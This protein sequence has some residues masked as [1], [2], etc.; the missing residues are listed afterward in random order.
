MSP[1]RCSAFQTGHTV[2]DS[3]TVPRLALGDALQRLMAES[4]AQEEPEE[5]PAVEAPDLPETPRAEGYKSAADFLQDE[6]SEMRQ[7]CKS[8]ILAIESFQNSE[9]VLQGQLKSIMADFAA[10]EEQAAETSLLIQKWQRSY[11]DE[12]RQRKAECSSLELELQKEAENVKN[13]PQQQLKLQAHLDQELHACEAMRDSTDKLEVEIREA[14]QSEHDDLSTV[15]AEMTA[16]QMSQNMVDRKLQRAEKEEQEQ[17]HIARALLEDLHLTEVAASSQENTL[18]QVKRVAEKEEESEADVLGLLEFR[19]SEMRQ[20]Q[21]AVGEDQEFSSPQSELQQLLSEL[22]QVARKS[23]RAKQELHEQ[24]QRT[25]DLA[26]RLQHLEDEASELQSAE[27]LALALQKSF[28]GT[29]RDPEVAAMQVQLSGLRGQ[30]VSH[31]KEQKALAGRLLEV[32]KTVPGAAVASSRFALEL[33][34]VDGSENAE[35]LQKLELLQAESRE[36]QERE[37]N[38]AQQLVQELPGPSPREDGLQ[39]E[40]KQE[41]PEEAPQRLVQDPQDPPAEPQVS[42]APAAEVPPSPA[43]VEAQPSRPSQ[44][45]SQ[46]PQEQ[47]L[48]GKAARGKEGKSR[49][50]K[51]ALRQLRHQLAEE[52]R[53]L[54]LWETSNTE[55]R[56]AM[57]LETQ[58]IS[59]SIR[60]IGIRCQMLVGKHRALLDDRKRLEAEA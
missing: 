28:K 19:E 39:P 56:H 4:E 12:M 15:R 40:Q 21:L 7:N 37:E 1:S 10:E 13:L 49:E 31:Q 9:K 60:E 25:E 17:L 38:S 44:A 24:Q 45:R 29:A 48:K 30:V 47:A 57:H 42:E 41:E 32:M 59:D 27:A 54:R 58:L 20:F 16:S 55:R 26:C 52:E 18:R 35:R 23:G 22:E 43:P 50:D 46:A 36:E 53:R 34:E 6:I 8:E 51:A 14:S 3:R 5:A 33:D 11:G 2:L